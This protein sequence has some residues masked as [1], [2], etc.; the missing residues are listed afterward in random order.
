MMLL[1]TTFDSLAW[2]PYTCRSSDRDPVPKGPTNVERE[3]RD[4]TPIIPML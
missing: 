1:W 2:R 4:A 3:R